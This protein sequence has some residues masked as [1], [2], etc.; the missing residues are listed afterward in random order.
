[1]I[2]IAGLDK[3]EVLAALANASQRIVNVDVTG[4]EFNPKLY[5]RNNVPGAAAR[6]VNNVRLQ[7]TPIAEAIKPAVE[8]K[9]QQYGKK[10]GLP[11]K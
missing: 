2:N 9:K 3:A 5:D 1:M 8:V 10:R 7:G 6:V 11:S 4:D